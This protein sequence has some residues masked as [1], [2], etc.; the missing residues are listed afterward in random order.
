MFDWMNECRWIDGER[1]E[2]DGKVE[3]I[4]ESSGEH[5]LMHGMDKILGGY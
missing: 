5:M 1:V 4:L 3:G 2:F